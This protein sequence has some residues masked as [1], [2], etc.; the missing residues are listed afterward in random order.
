MT[1]EILRI[2][3]WLLLGVLLIGFAI[4]DG[5]DLGTAALLP[6]SGAT[7][8]SA[9]SPS[10]ASGRCGKATRSG[11][12]LAAAR[13]SPPGRRFMPRAFSGFY[14]AMFLVL[15]ALIMRPVGF[16]FRSKLVDARWRSWW[17]W[18]LCIGGIVPPLVFGV[19]FGN[20]FEGVPF[21]FDADLRMQ[22]NITLWSLLNPFALLC[23]LV[24]LAMIAVH[25]AAWLNSRRRGPVQDRA[26]LALPYAALAYSVLFVIAG[27]WVGGLGGYALAGIVDPDAPSNPL[28]K[29]VLLGGGWL[30]RFEAH[31]LLWVCRSPP[32][33]PR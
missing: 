17:D 21:G 31:P 12:S 3:W 15:A 6:L 33:S 23:G 8:W 22:S 14:L 20:L 25:G 30:R 19:A 18:T 1:Y 29:T 11:S 27:L 2:I 16:K 7:T 5:F 4:M 24:S 32:C 10:T 13:S 26:R 9:A 28:G